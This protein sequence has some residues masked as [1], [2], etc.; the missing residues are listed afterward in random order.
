MTNNVSPA[1]YSGKTFQPATLNKA[2]K[3]NDDGNNNVTFLKRIDTVNGALKTTK[4]KA[5][6]DLRSGDGTAK[7][8]WSDVNTENA[9]EVRKTISVIR[10]LDEKNPTTITLTQGGKSLSLKLPSGEEVDTAVNN[11]GM[12]NEQKDLAKRILKSLTLKFCV[13]T[14]DKGFGFQWIQ[15]NDGKPA[16]TASGDDKDGEG[17]ITADMA[18]LI[19]ELIGKA[20]KN[21][22]GE[23]LYN[24]ITEDL[25]KESISKDDFQRVSNENKRLLKSY[26][27]NLNNNVD[28]NIFIPTGYWKVGGIESAVNEAEVKLA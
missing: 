14:G 24:K 4:L 16:K 23:N 6:A 2:S 12:S 15:P 5:I 10:G 17:Q 20:N 18:E 3:T 13:P 26:P 25:K 1:F 28:V 11:S 19:N 27:I 21:E 22:K 7:I 8:N 9:Q